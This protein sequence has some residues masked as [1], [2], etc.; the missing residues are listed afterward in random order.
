MRIAERNVTHVAAPATVTWLS[1][2]AA[3]ADVETEWRALESLVHHRTHVST[4][5]F[6][7]PW[8]EHYAGEYGGTPLV[9]LARRGS[10][11][12]AVAP[13]VVR[14]GRLGRVPVTRVEFAPNDSIA[15]EFL[16]RDDE[17]GVVADLL[18]SLARRIRFDAICLNGFE[19]GSAQLVALR[20]AARRHKLG[21]ELEDHAFARV[22]LSAGYQHYYASLSGD[23][24]RKLAHRARKIAAAG[25]RVDGVLPIS[26]SSEAEDRLARLI[27]INEA[28]YK[29]EGRPLADHHKRFLR[30][31]VHGLAARGKLSL[32]ILTI[33]GRD[34]AFILGVI[35]RGCFYDVTLSYDEAFA[36]LGPGMYLLQEVLRQLADGGL[37]TLVSHGAHE[38][39]RQWASAFVPQKRL[40]L[41]APRPR[42]FVTRL[43]KFHVHPRL[44]R[45]KSGPD[46]PLSF[47]RQQCLSASQTDTV[48]SGS[49][50][51]HVDTS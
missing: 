2:P 1:S 15:G 46:A 35:E 12:V 14:Q 41:F 47:D 6:L 30:D 19:P 39:K 18:D 40:F 21:T 11:L 31:L 34:A 38:Y 32:P 8:Y 27:V 25:V 48:R 50:A 49:G 9:G 13:L 28:S 3:L 23:F 43:L 4:F 10:E 7:A 5:D 33:G 20:Q 44:E 36:R 22:D 37:H 51:T 26:S 45:L 17:P 24:R 16:V 29:L 42:A